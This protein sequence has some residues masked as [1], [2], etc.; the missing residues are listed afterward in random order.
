MPPK[1]RFR[2]IGLLSGGEKT[3]AS[4]SLI[5]ALHTFRPAPFYVFDELDSALDKANV[6]KLVSFLAGLQVQLVVITLK[7]QVF[8]HADALIGVYKDQERNSSR[9]LSYRFD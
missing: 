4:L 8:Q 2:E 7:P 5:F 1:K 3:M 9:V 6:A